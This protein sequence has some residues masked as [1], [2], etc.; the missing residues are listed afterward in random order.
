MRLRVKGYGRGAF[1]VV[2]PKGSSE[3]FLPYFVPSRML[4]LFLESV[5]CFVTVE[6]IIFYWDLMLINLFL[7]LTF[8]MDQVR[9][10]QTAIF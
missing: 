9:G 3:N 2:I 8:D 7:S 1:L 4:T 6:K 10:R 5:K